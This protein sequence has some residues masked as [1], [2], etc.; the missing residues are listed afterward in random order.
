M[1]VNDARSLA[2]SSVDRSLERSVV[3]SLGRSGWGARGPP[4]PT[5][6]GSPPDQILADRQTCRRV[7]IQTLRWLSFRIPTV[8]Y[9]FCILSLRVV[10]FGFVRVAKTGRL[11][12]R[13]PSNA[14][15]GP[16]EGGFFDATLKFYNF[17]KY[18]GR[19]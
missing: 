11:D 2:R 16:T 8:V 14:L 3:R 5:P 9:R 12:I 17:E 6:R 10:S 18:L 1:L 13:R 15:K 7:S 4:P 19:F